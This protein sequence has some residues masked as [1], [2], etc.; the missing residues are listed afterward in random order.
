[1]CISNIYSRLL[2]LWNQFQFVVFFCTH[3]LVTITYF[4]PLY[5]SQDVCS[6]LG[7]HPTGR[8]VLAEYVE[9][10]M[11]LRRKQD[12]IHILTAEIIDK[13]GTL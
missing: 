10:G 7:A 8:A 4:I 3:L 2:L 6:I 12:M 5:D 13:S 9:S 11:V 1:M